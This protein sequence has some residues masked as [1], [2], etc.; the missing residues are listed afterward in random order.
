MVNKGPTKKLKP[1]QSKVLIMPDEK[2]AI[3]KALRLHGITQTEAGPRVGTTGKL[4][5]G[6]LCYEG[7]LITSECLG[8]LYELIGYDSSLRFIENY[9]PQLKDARER[10]SAPILTDC[11]IPP[12]PDALRAQDTLYANVT[13]RLKAAFDYA[14]IYR[15]ADILSALENLVCDK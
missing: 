13:V 14:P 7:R 10:S 8:G 3:K 2:E 9:L 1:G 4:L 6:I 11:A 5:N 15:R 12:D